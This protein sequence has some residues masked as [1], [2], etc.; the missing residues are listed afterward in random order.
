[1]K[2]FLIAASIIAG[3]AL[4]LTLED[5]R[6]YCD[7]Q[8]RT[9]GTWIGQDTNCVF[10]EWGIFHPDGTWEEINKLPLP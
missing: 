9:D 4:I 6:P 5:D 7:I 3:Y 2:S 10:P 8:V 1:M